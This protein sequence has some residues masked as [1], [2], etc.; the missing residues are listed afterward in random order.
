MN[1]DGVSN[2]SA[3]FD[4]IIINP[5]Y[6]EVSEEEGRES[7]E[8][9]E[10]RK[11]D[12]SERE[13][14]LYKLSYDGGKRGNAVIKKLL[15]ECQEILGVEGKLIFVHS[16]LNGGL[17]F[18]GENCLKNYKFKILDQKKFHNE[19]LYTIEAAKV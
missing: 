10:R 14:N 9:L 1:A 19:L 3:L 18:L 8:Q 6:I 11:L 2:L 13:G 7:R 17:G 4:F 16:N 12:N 15:K 5:P